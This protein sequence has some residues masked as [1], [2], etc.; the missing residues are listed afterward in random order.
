MTIDVAEFSYITAV[1]MIPVFQCQVDHETGRVQRYLSMGYDR[2]ESPGNF[3]YR[4]AKATLEMAKIDLERARRVVSEYEQRKAASTGVQDGTE[5][6]SDQGQPE[7]ASVQAE[8]GREDGAVPDPN[9]GAD[10]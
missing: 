1:A 7:G 9:Q 4:S 3:F 5:V 8:T 10:S 2:P 6:V